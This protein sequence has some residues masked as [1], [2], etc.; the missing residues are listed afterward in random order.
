MLKFEKKICR[1]KVKRVEF[2]SNMMYK[3]CIVLRGCWC[4]IN[5]LNA[6]APVEEKNY[7]FEN[8][9]YKQLVLNFILTT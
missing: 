4:D 8:S 2:F 7:A 5:I 1:Q 9:L 3:G 6:H